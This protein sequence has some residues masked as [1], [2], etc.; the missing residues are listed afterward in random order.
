MARRR[1]FDG[2]SHRVV[3]EVAEHGGH[4]LHLD[5]RCQ[6]QR[7]RVDGYAYAAL[8]CLEAMGADEGMQEAVADTVDV[9]DGVVDGPRCSCSPRNS[10][11]SPGRSASSMPTATCRRLANSCR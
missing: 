8:A 9:L 11:A 5:Q 7:V 3:D 2:G 10:R 4:I 6:Q 1:P